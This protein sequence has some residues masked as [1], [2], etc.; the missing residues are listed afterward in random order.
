MNPT[1]HTKIKN[2]SIMDLLL[3]MQ[4]SLTYA[5]CNQQFNDFLRRSRQQFSD[6]FQCV[7]FIKGMSYFELQTQVKSHRSQQKDNNMPLAE[8][9]IS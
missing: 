1:F 4:G 3:L 7:T 2:D 9:H 5:A 8:L 6:E